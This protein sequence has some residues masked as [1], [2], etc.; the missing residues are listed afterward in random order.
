MKL[1]NVP[2]LFDDIQGH[3]F[4]ELT[5]ILPDTI[6]NILGIFFGYILSRE[7]I[8]K[9]VKSKKEE[10]RVKWISLSNHNFGK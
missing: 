5:D 10:M 9:R 2:I 7:A 8:E 3:L 1:T 4:H 6:F